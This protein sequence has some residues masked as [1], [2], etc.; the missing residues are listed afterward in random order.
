MASHEFLPLNVVPKFP[1]ASPPIRT[2]F[3]L[4]LGKPQV[5]Y[6]GLEA[7]A[8]PGECTLAVTTLKSVRR[9]CLPGEITPPY[10]GFPVSGVTSWSAI[11]T[12]ATSVLK[13]CVKQKK[14][15]V[16]WGRK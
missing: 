5:S 14:T 7:D 12:S 13:R 11:Y 15:G 16:L 2:P 3:K 9:G 8:V 6:E 4:T 1:Y 10:G